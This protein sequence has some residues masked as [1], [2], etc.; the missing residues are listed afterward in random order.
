M[1]LG[2]TSMIVG[3]MT[4]R[5]LRQSAM[6]TVLAAVLMLFT[7]LIRKYVE[8]FAKTTGIVTYSCFS[9]ARPTGTPNT[10]TMSVS[11]ASGPGRLSSTTTTS[12]SATSGPSRLSRP[13][14]T[15]DTFPRACQTADTCH[16]SDFAKEFRLD[17]ENVPFTSPSSPLIQLLAASPATVPA[18]RFGW[19]LF[20]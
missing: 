20:E 1:V 8:H 12:V 18:Q 14:Q 10:T 4:S 17:C 7:G 2:R 19:R 11:A 9:R 5:F 15:A 3:S 13:S 16:P 6:A